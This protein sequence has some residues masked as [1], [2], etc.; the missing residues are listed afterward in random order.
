[1]HMNYCNHLSRYVK[2]ILHL[3]MSLAFSDNIVSNYYSL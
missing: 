1:M 3:T 2:L